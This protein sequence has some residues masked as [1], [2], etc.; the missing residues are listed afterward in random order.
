[1]RGSCR[2]LFGNVVDEEEAA[3]YQD[4]ARVTRG[5]P[6]YVAEDEPEDQEQDEPTGEPQPVC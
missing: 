6:L 4:A 2:E 1:M 3:R 5:Q